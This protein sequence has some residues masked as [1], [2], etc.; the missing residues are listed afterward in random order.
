MGSALQLPRDLRWLGTATLAVGSSTNT[1]E[2][3]LSTISLPDLCI[4][5]DCGREIPFVNLIKSHT[6]WKSYCAGISFR[7]RHRI[8]ALHCQVVD[9]GEERHK[10]VPG[11]QC[12]G[13]YKPSDFNV[14]CHRQQAE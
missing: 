12:L 4:R 9:V 2:T 13:S 3:G 11:W 6:R 10:L 1:P 8:Q 7:A 5:L 14:V